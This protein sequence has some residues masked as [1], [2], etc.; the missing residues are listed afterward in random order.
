MEQGPDELALRV[1]VREREPVRIADLTVRGLDLLAPGRR[2]LVLED[3]P[4]RP[5]EVF[6]ERRWLQAKT[7]IIDRLKD[8]GHA[9]AALVGEAR[10]DLQANRGQ[11]D[12]LVDPGPSYRFGEVIVNAPPGSKVDPA[13]V[14]EQ[15]DLALGSD[16]QLLARRAG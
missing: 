5:E 11:L 6:L 14:R 8:D 1:E 16:R 2:E 12:L 9:A 4:L 3:L 7:L 10:L 13:L 15:I